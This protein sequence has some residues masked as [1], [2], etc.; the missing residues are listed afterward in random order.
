M[1]TTKPNFLAQPAVKSVRVYRNGDPFFAGR[2]FVI[3]ERQIST[4]EA[5]LKEV[6]NGLEPPFGAVRNIYT[7]QQGHRVYQL[8]ELDS[9]KQYVAGGKERFKKL[10]YIQIGIKKTK[11]LPKDVQIKPVAHSRIIASARFRKLTQEPCIICVIANGDLLNPAIRLLIPKRILG[12]WEQVLASITE[13]VNLRTGAVRKLHTLDGRSINDGSELENGGYYV[14]VGRDKFKKLP[15]NELIFSKSCP[16]RTSRSKAASL[17][18]I[19]GSKKNKENGDR[20]IRSTGTESEVYPLTLSESPKRK[21]KKEQV[22]AKEESVFHAKPI[23]VK[24]DKNGS[25]SP[26]LSPENESCVFKAYEERRETMGAMEVQEDNQTQVELPIDQRPAEIVEEEE[27]LQEQ[28]KEGSYDEGDGEFQNVEEEICNDVFYKEETPMPSQIE[29]YPNLI[30]N[31]PEEEKNGI[32]SESI[33][34]VEEEI[35]NIV[36]QEVEDAIQPEENSKDKYFHPDDLPQKEETIEESEAE[37]QVEEEIDDLAGQEE[38]DAD[39][40]EEGPKDKY[41]PPQDLSREEEKIIDESEAELQ[42]E[43]EVVDLAEQ[44][45]EIA[46]Q[47]EEKPQD[48]FLPNEEQAVEESEAELQVEEEVTDLVE[49][50]EE[51]VDQT[52]EGP[53]NDYFPPEDLPNEEKIIDES[54]AEPQVEEEIADLAEEEGADQAEENCEDEFQEKDLDQELEESSAE[55]EAPLKE[56]ESE[57]VSALELNKDDNILEE[58]LASPAESMP[59]PLETDGKEIIQSA[60]GHAVLAL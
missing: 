13:K 48:K 59:N 11:P 42:V 12:Q 56:R 45:E 49:R 35:A 14:A 32:A 46:N 24:P 5:F 37:P 47:S 28:F 51:D 1:A 15:Y 10:D 60:T 27:N 4:F 8:E 41:F 9:G 40:L 53:K 52:E 57:I 58:I 19:P 55:Q 21:G 30:V 6:T 36:E 54:E 31:P 7:P 22:L 20:Q 34:Q 38:E 16:R 43:E 33:P 17:P 18:P 3:N 23:K 44:E 2:K 39:Q 29:E 26:K 50:E 25:G